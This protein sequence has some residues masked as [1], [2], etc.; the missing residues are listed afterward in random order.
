MAP[1][2]TMTTRWPSLLSRT[3]VSTI[4]D[5]M[6]SIGWCVVSS[7]IE[8]DPNDNTIVRDFFDLVRNL[9]IGALKKGMVYHTNLY[10]YGQVS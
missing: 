7:T 2:E 4:N 6:E 5:K 10:N 8:L 1:E 3:T 9:N